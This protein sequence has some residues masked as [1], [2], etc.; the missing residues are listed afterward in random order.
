MYLYVY[1]RGGRNEQSVERI[2][3][4]VP[5][6]RLLLLFLSVERVIMFLF[7]ANTV[8]KLAD[9]DFR[10][11]II[12]NSSFVPTLALCNS[13]SD[14]LYIKQMKYDKYYM[15]ERN[16]QAIYVLHISS[17]FLS[18]NLVEQLS[19]RVCFKENARKC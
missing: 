6:R 8:Q 17:N 10:T 2:P 5:P 16:L 13:K 9:N 18:I 14:E 19:S 7:L 11:I 1:L 15:I 3:P 4:P 12:D